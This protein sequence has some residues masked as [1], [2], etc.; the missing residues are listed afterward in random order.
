M[1]L[2]RAFFEKI[3]IA[4]FL[5]RLTNYNLTEAVLLG[6]LKTVLGRAFS[7]NFSMEP[8]CNICKRFETERTFA[9]NSAASAIYKFS[10]IQS[11]RIDSR[12]SFVSI[13]LQIIDLR[14]LS[15]PSETAAETGFSDKKRMLRIESPKIL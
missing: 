4:W 3:E 1:A 11:I 2:S 5:L 9:E 13:V 6:S 8:F 14:L 10:G 12:F 15:F 7:L